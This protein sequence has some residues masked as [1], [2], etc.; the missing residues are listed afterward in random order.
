MDYQKAEDLQKAAGDN[1][2]MQEVADRCG[3]TKF[4][5][6]KW[7]HRHSVRFRFPTR[8]LLP[9]SDDKFREIVADN[10]TVAGILRDLGRAFVGT[11]YKL[12]HREVE[13]LGLDTSHWKGMAHGSGI[14][15]KIP[16]ENVLVRDSPYNLN[17][18]RK[19]RLI[20]EGLL[21]NLC[22]VCGREPEWQGKKLVLVLD[23]I[24]GIHTDHRLKNLRLVCPNC[25]SQLPTFC[26]RNK[27]RHSSSGRTPD[28]KSA[29][30]GS[31]PL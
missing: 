31:T 19:T 22:A 4:T 3:V 2:T 15:K 12:I 13:R 24:N 26:G 14:Q 28:S 5:I 9:C 1:L 10:F 25:D 6:Q 17:K 11:N 16:W 20:R 29:G 23:H 30:R 27:G 21:T 7:A 8:K 18:L